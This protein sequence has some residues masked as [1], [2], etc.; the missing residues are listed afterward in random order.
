[1]GFYEMDRNMFT[2]S[3]HDSRQIEKLAPARFILEQL[4]KLEYVPGI[5]LLYRCG[6][7]TWYV[8]FA[9]IYLIIRKRYIE[10]VVTIP[11]MVNILVCLISPVNTCI[12]YAMPTMCMVPVI[13]AIIL[14]R[15]LNCNAELSNEA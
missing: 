4:S 10:V 3:M 9:V 11:A 8:M 7:Y 12:R 5:G 2:K 13:F 15:K 14:S 6:F 1:M